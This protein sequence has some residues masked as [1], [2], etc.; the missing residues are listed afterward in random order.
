MGT[1]LRHG[2]NALMEYITVLNYVSGEEAGDRDH[3]RKY[4]NY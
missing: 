2:F 1:L 3:F 4:T